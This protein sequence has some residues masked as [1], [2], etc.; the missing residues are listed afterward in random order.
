MNLRKNN[1]HISIEFW[2]EQS[3]ELVE[4]VKSRVGGIG[5]ATWYIKIVWF[6]PKE[7]QKAI[8]NELPGCKVI[9]HSFLLLFYHLSYTQL[10]KCDFFLSKG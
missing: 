3:K 10:S 8:I 7:R 6:V 4:F 2:L 5:V 1:E 9:F